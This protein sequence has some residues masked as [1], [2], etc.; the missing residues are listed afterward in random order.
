MTVETLHPR[1]LSRSHS[2]KDSRG[3]V[4][5]RIIAVAALILTLIVLT[6][7]RTVIIVFIRPPKSAL[8][9]YTPCP[10]WEDEDTESSNDLHNH[11]DSRCDRD[12]NI[13]RLVEKISVASFDCSVVGMIVNATHE[14]PRSP[15]I[16]PEEMKG[17]AKSPV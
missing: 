6:V 12:N 2:S 9:P 4:D 15:I 17:P 8:S 13:C 7:V 5:K 3:R 10:S 14:N 11:R 1:G 16:P